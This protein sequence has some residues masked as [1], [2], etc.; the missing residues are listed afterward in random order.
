MEVLK[1]LDLT[2]KFASFGSVGL[3]CFIVNR[4]V[5]KIEIKKEIEKK[6]NVEV[7]RLNTMVYGVRRKMKRSARGMTIGAV[8][9]YKKAIVKLKKGFYIDVL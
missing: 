3:Y 5:N 2:K 1:K 4:E 6:Y 7:E 8:S 9:S